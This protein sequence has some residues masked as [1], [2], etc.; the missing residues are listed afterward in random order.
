M[1]TKRVLVTGSGGFI[2]GWVAKKLISLGYRVVGIDSLDETL[3]SANFKRTTI[4]ELEKAGMVFLHQK[5]REVDF[6]TLDFEWIVHSS[7]IPGL[8]KSWEFP[9]SYVEANV[10]DSAHLAMIASR[11]QVERFIHLSTSSVYGNI[12]NGNENHPKKPISPYG[13]TKLAAEKIIQEIL[14]ESNTELKILRLFSVYGPGQRADM[15][16][17]KMMKAAILGEAFTIYGDGAQIRANTYVQDVVGAVLSALETSSRSIVFNIAGHEKVSLMHA[18]ETFEKIAKIEVKVR[19][20]AK[21]QGD[22]VYTVPDLSL[23]HKELGYT[24]LTSFE[25][26]IERQWS[27]IKDL[28]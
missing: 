27:W 20:S 7:A 24:P 23:A 17:H 6:S 22:Q 4:S 10:L 3:T 26:G 8:Q 15:A 16:Y 14:R 19:K 25:E 5:I 9:E 2:G 21:V 1:K 13:I 18:V 12:R 28:Y 11:M